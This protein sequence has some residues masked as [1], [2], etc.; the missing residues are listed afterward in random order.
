MHSSARRSRVAPRD[1]PP[2]WQPLS[3]FCPSL[4]HPATDRSTPLS[5][6]LARAHLLQDKFLDRTR[7][8]LAPTTLIWHPPP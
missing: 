6:S 7:P 4:S 2:S 5:L 8:N 3:A 1:R